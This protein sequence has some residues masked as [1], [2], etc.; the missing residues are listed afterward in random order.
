MQNGITLK[1][2][3]VWLSYRFF[4]VQ[5]RM[6]EM[7]VKKVD[8]RSHK[9]GGN[10]G[11]GAGKQAAESAGDNTDEIT[12][13]SAKPERLFTLVGNDNGNG[14]VHGNAQIGGHVQRGGKAHQ[15]DSDYQQYYPDCHRGRRKPSADGK[16]GKIGNVACEKHVD[17]GGDTDVMP[18]QY[19]VDYQHEK[20]DAGV[21][22]TVG[23]AAHE[24]APAALRE[25]LERID[26][27][28]GAF[29]KAH[30]NGAENDAGDGHD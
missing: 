16:L 27:K 23:N 6:R 10:Q 15:N 26:S 13:D 17:K 7:N 19:Q 28:K 12:A 21:V 29:K 8:K 24:A 2:K 5:Q 18:I 22:C 11:A 20:A 4:S 1:A 3:A 14:V 30:G 9:K 25:A